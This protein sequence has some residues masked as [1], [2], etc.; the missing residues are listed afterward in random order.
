MIPD[1]Q[2]N[3][4]PSAEGPRNGSEWSY[5]QAFARHQGLLNRA[6]Q[7]RLRRSRVAIVGMGGVGGVDS[8][9]GVD[10]CG[11]RAPVTGS[12][13]SPMRAS[14]VSSILRIAGPGARRRSPRST[15]GRPERP[16]VARHS[17]ARS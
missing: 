3:A 16:S 9:S 7:D 10:A 6:E 1:A 8:E 11:P 13:A 4:F 12:G 15:T 5:E 14:P 17:L 2:R